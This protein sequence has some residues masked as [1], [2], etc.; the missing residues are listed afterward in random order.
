MVEVSAENA[1]PGF[2]EASPDHGTAFA[3]AGEGLAREGSRAAAPLAA[4]ELRP[5]STLQDC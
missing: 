1:S 3:L 4:A 2:P 5:L